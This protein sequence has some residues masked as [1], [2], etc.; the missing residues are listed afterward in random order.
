MNN[1]LLSSE[2]VQK[3]NPIIRPMSLG[4]SLL[5]FGVP[6]LVLFF[7][8]HVVMPDLIRC[9]LAP[10]YAYFI[11]IG[12]PLAIMFVASLVA[13]RMEGNLM[14]R[15]ALKKRFRLYRLSGK[16]WLLTIGAFAVIFILYGIAIRINAML[17]NSGII[18]MPSSLPAWLDTTGGM[19]GMTAMDQA[20]GGLSGNWLALIAYVVFLCFNVIGE[21]FWWRGYILPRQELAFGKW[22]W[23]IHGLLW[24]FFHAFKWWDILGIL[25]L[26]LMIPFL[27]WRF[28]NNTIG[29]VL[30]F[31]INGLGL[32]PILL[33]IL[34]VAI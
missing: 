13:Y 26:A 24:A 22:A 21:E 27:V 33:G 16:M 9:G 2:E 15:D 30:H 20:F 25:P 29:I 5:F 32:I 28:R 8:F 12:I 10:F 6:A 34:G 17:L 4:I 18:P 23:I 14:T 1:D 7:G 11:G 31:L 19:P 3:P